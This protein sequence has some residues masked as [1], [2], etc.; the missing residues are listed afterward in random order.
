MVAVAV[1]S[2]IG[3][4]SGGLCEAIL[5][6]GTG[7]NRFLLLRPVMD[8]HLADC[9]DASGLRLNRNLQLILGNIKGA[10]FSERLVHVMLPLSK[11]V[12]HNGH[13]AARIHCL[14]L[15]SVTLL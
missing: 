10:N 7:A 8:T 4:R 2:A 6:R 15:V 9:V 11:E 1:D 14:Q 12:Q 3:T 13:S 5:P